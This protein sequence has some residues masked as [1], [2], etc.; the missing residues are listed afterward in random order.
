MRGGALVV[1]DERR[2][3]RI[4]QRRRSMRVRSEDDV[5]RYICQALVRGV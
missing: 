2:R 3:A 1:D 4:R 5:E